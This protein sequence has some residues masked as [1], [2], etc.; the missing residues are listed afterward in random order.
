MLV[1]VILFILSFF[2]PPLWIVFGIYLVWLFMTASKRRNA[3][4]DS[5]IKKM[6]VTGRG[7]A[8]LKHVYWEAAAKYAVEHGAQM[9]KY[10][11]SPSDETVYSIEHF[12]FNGSVYSI[13]LSREMDGSTYIRDYTEELKKIHEDV[14]NRFG[15]H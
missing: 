12:P 13:M 3:I 4:L 1:L 11:K 9:S 2:F 8:I 15:S 7:E 5:E 6:L 14:L 10:S